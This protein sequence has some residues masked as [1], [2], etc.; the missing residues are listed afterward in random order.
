M[1]NLAYVTAIKGPR[2]VRVIA[3]AVCRDG[4]EIKRFAVGR[5]YWRIA[6]HLAN[7]LREDINRGIA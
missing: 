5:G 4:A 6:L 7:T 3:Y 2:G 1:P